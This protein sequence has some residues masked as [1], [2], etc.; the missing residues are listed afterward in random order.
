M[1]HYGMGMICTWATLVS[2][3]RLLNGFVKAIPQYQNQNLCSRVGQIN[4]GGSL[5]TQRVKAYC[6]VFWKPSGEEAGCFSFHFY[7]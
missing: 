4:Q 7:C 2:F 3:S 1:R 5:P 6:L